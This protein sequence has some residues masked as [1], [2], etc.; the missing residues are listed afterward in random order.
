MI[1]EAIFGI[2]LLIVPSPFM[3][4]SGITLDEISTSLARLLGSALISFPILLWFARKSEHMDFK[5]G[6]CYT[7][8][9]YYLVGGVLLLLSQLAGLMNPMGWGLVGI[10]V[11]MVVWFGYYI[12]K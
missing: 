12:F 2:S 3:S 10:H 1:L 8:F 7:M 5:R 6:A 9:A 4:L 11:I